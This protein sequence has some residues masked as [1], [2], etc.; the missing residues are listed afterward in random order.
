MA[1]SQLKYDREYYYYAALLDDSLTLEEKQSEYARLR[2]IANARLRVL[3]NSEYSDDYRVRR[4]ADRFKPPKKI[5]DE[6]ELNALLSEVANIIDN[7][8]Y[9]L[10]GMRRNERQVLSML[11]RHYDFIL[12]DR[13]ELREFGEFMDDFRNAGLEAIYG[14]D[15]V[16]RYLI[17]KQDRYE[18]ATLQGFQQYAARRKKERAEGRASRK[19]ENIRYNRKKKGRK[20]K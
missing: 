6:R 9:T 2:K 12:R 11:E 20:R 17:Y 14:S 19:P 18:E 7:P 1:E 4:Y 5:R 10:E 15:M 13:A 16:I 8:M 3:K